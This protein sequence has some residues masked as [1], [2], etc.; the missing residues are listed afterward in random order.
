M[1]PAARQAVP[2][3]DQ[4]RLPTAQT[5][6][7]GPPSVPRCSVFDPTYQAVGSC[8]GGHNVTTVERCGTPSLLDLTKGCGNHIHCAPCAPP[9]FATLTHLEL[10]PIGIPCLQFGKMVACPMCKDGCQPANKDRLLNLLYG[11]GYQ[12]ILRKI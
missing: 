11:N 9:P 4:P 5:G 2:P 12:I 6:L 10:P 8:D 7:R 1:Q 3:A